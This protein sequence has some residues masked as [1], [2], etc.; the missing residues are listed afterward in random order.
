MFIHISG[1]LTCMALPAECRRG[2]R[3]ISTP[4]FH[5]KLTLQAC[6]VRECLLNRETRSCF[7]RV[8]QFYDRRYVW[9]RSC[10]VFC[11]ASKMLMSWHSFFRVGILILWK[12]SLFAF[13]F[14]WCKRFLPEHSLWIIFL[15]MRK[16]LHID[17]GSARNINS[18]DCRLY[19]RARARVVH[20]PRFQ[21]CVCFGYPQAVYI[22]AFPIL[23]QGG[24]WLT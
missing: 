9:V 3:F 24:N 13:E 5:D 7:L 10:K 22:A 1:V 18:P 23:R 6:L 17:F 11:K 12:M 19:A 2:L 16:P 14:V 8:S 4:G 21:A 20:A 15:F